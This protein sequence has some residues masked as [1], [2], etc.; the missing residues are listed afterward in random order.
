[1]IVKL[2]ANETLLRWVCQGVPLLIGVGVVAAFVLRLSYG[3]PLARLAPP[4]AVLVG[5]Q[6]LWF[7]GM[8]GARKRY[9]HT[10][11]LRIGALVTGTYGLCIV[12][13]AM[14]YAGQLGIASERTFEDNYVEFSVFMAVVTCIVVV[15]FSFVRP[16]PNS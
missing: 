4:I 14:Y 13:A 7:V 9:R 16:R 8:Y 3:L 11:D 1:V 6:V 10:G 5:I 2:P 15:I 12:L